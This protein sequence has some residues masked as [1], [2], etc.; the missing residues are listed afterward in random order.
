MNPSPINL[1]SRL[2]LSKA[3]PRGLSGR[4][5]AHRELMNCTSANLPRPPSGVRRVLT[6]VLGVA[7]KAVTTPQPGAK[8]DSRRRSLRCAL[9]EVMRL[10]EL[11]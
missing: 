3:T 8:T 2:H 10:P 1:G 7:C 11:A 4:P 5:G 9:V 6:E